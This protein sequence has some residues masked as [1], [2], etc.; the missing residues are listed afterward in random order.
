[1]C[2]SQAEGGTRCAAHTRPRYKA[3]RFGTVE[4][5]EAAAEFASTRSGAAELK[6]EIGST[7]SEDRRAALTSA[8]TRGKG[9]A[10][11]NGEVRRQV[12]AAA[13]VP[14]AVPAIP[15]E[16]QMRP[17]FDE[18]S[19][20]WVLVDDHGRAFSA[21]GRKVFEFHQ[22][23]DAEDWKSVAAAPARFDRWIPADTVAPVGAQMW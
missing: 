18:S 11:A 23:E 8:L 15:P 13:K 22:A 2:R 16:S 4:W 12:A 20:M 6:A 14:A 9:L 19:Q 7:G 5:D 17:S 3:A 21:D 1:M 10:E